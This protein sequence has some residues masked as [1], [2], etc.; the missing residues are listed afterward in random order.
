MILN[1]TISQKKLAVVDD[2]ARQNVLGTC[3]S[4]RTRSPIL[5]RLA[6]EGELK[7]CGAM[8]DV[9]SGKVELL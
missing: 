2:I 3:E 7:I 9:A 5:A 4:L 6:Q 1:N 8:Y